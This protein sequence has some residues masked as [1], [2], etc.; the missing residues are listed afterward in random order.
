VRCAR[1]RRRARRFLRPPPR[2]ANGGGPGPRD[3]RRGAL[4]RL[5]HRVEVP[6]RRR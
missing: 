6:H 3:R 5:R 1:T 2:R 4:W